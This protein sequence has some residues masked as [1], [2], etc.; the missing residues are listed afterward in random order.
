[1]QVVHGYLSNHVLLTMLS[2][3]S[4]PTFAVQTMIVQ[5]QQGAVAYSLMVLLSADLRVF[6]ELETYFLCLRTDID[7]LLKYSL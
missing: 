1:M 7:I 5:E 3:L 6:I 2:D 4:V